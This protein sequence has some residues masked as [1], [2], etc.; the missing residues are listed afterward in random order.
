MNLI[1][2]ILDHLWAYFY[3]LFFLFFCHIGMRDNFLLISNVIYKKIK[4]T[5]VKSPS[6]KEDSP[7]FL[8]GRWSLGGRGMGLITWTN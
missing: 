4:E 1:I 7:F 8:L 6:S 3:S 2:L 5:L